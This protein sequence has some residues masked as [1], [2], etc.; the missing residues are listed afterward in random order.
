[1]ESASAFT[2]AETTCY[3]CNDPLPLSPYLADD[4]R[5]CCNGCKQVYLLLS[6]HELGQYYQQGTE[7]GIKPSEDHY[8]F[9]QF[10][11][12]EL[13]QKW[14][15]F[16]EGSTVKID[17]H[18]PQIHCECCIYLLEH[19]SKLHEGIR[20]SS[21][22]FPNKT[23]S[24]TYDSELIKLS[25]LAQLLTKI[26][27]TPDFSGNMSSRNTNKRLLLQLG[28]AGFAFGSIML[29]SFPEYLGID[30]TYFGVRNLSSWLSLLVSVPVLLYSAQ[31]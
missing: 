7:A 14:I 9:E 27:Y 28:V 24:I 25:E 6:S 17:L 18:L 20:F 26:G 30:Y 13:Q 22:N 23:A 8:Y 15:T 31:Y 12:P 3:H 29:W 21:V 19:L 5:F 2:A 16:Q 11:L 10:D 4:Q 1:M